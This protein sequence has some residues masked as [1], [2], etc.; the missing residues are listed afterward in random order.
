MGKYIINGKLVLK[1]QILEDTLYIEGDKIARIGG[2]IDDSAEIIDAQ[3]LYVSPGFIDTHTHGRGGKDTMDATFESLNIMS[4]ETLKTGVTTF[5]PTTMTMP[6]EDIKKA[7]D[8][9]AKYKDQVEGAQILGTHLEGPFFSKKYKGAQPESAM[10]D[11]T[12]ENYLSFVCDH[13]DIIRKI[14]LAPELD[15]CDELITY[16]KDKKTIVSIGHTN[17]T[18]EQAMKAVEL[19]ATAGTHTYNAM[20]PLTH[21]A[22]GVVGACML[23]DK[24][25]SELILD[26]LHVSYPAA[27]VLLKAKGVDRITLVTDSLEA[28]GL[29]AGEY[30]LAGQ[31]IF[32]VDGACRLENGTLAGSIVGMNTEVN[33]AIK[34]LG[35]S[36][37]DAVKMASTNIAECLQEDLIGEIKEGHYADIIFFDDDVNI[38]K[39][40]IKGEVR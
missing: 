26:G 27:K 5:L 14:S 33:N 9:I 31:P 7:V 32:V 19:G 22:P 29:P 12:V 13:Q 10:I 6:A 8:A 3:G 34:N 38:H 25:Y 36:V 16:L 4:K 15:H 35:V 2:D 28:A 40:I 1:N 18:F 21:R 37:V 24:I 39:V 11:P 20:T 23:S 17:A 30:S